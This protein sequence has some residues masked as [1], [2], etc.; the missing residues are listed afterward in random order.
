MPITLS[1]GAIISSAAILI[2]YLKR[3]VLYI[4]GGAIIALGAWCGL[5]DLL[6]RIAFD[7]TSELVWSTFPLV[8]CFII[9]M[10]LIIIEIV[11]P[12]KESLRKIFFI[13]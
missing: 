1:F 2:H 10:M 5:L 7:I 13:G 12:F 11:K 4:I 3:G 6:S 8:F 9:G